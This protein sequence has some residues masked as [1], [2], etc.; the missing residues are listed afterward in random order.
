[1]KNPNAY[2]VFLVMSGV[3]T[4]ASTTMF[5]VMTVYF[6]TT[7]GLDPLQL[8]LVG[9]VLETTALV[10][11]APTGVVA[12]TFSR[13]LSV[14]LGTFILGAGFVLVGAIPLFAILLVSQVITGIGYT[15]LSGATEAWLAD[16]VG[17]EHIGTALL[18][19]GQVD[20]VAGI[21]G[22]IAS[23]A[24]AS[25]Q[26]NLPILIGGGLFLALGVFLVLR[27][28]ETGFKPAR[29]EARTTWQTFGHTFRA[30]ARVVRR[31]PVLL[32]LLGV[33]FFAGAAS[34]GFDRLGDAHL[35]ANFTLPA[36]GALQPVVWFGIIGVAS[37]LVTLAVTE[38]LRKRLE[39]IS[40]TSRATPRV[41]LVLSGLS[42]V[43]VVVFGLAGNFGMA[44]AAL[45]AKEVF[46]S[47]NRPL[48]AAWLIQHID[49]R[50]RATVLSM[51]GQVNAIGQ[52]GGGPGIG[53]IGNAVSIRAAIV[54]AGLLLSP[55]LLLYTRAMR[56]ETTAPI[57]IGG[58][59][60]EASANV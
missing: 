29:R 32:M 51:T 46:D 2:R 18:R 56:Q 20:R 8:V 27:M 57:P 34:E 59:E 15:F 1:M 16:E 19:A 33:N 12:D 44:V 5:T 53:L 21:A 58:E 7:V 28:P 48:Y 13:R 38:V 6:F 11:E 43:S 42:I 49:P 37:A 10:F 4:F 50:V 41:L 17:E 55:V 24:L 30:G 3:Q 9:A 54:A 40:R 47:L 52:I 25:I 26:L 60:Q 45:L 36:L 31:S 22:T 35:L 14:I 39:Q 23:V